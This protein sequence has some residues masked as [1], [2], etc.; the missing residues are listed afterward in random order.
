[1]KKLLV[2]ITILLS[3]FSFQSCR[4]TV[5]V[6]PT[7]PVIAARPPIPHPGYV[8]VDGEW[9][10]SGGRY[11]YRQGYWTSPRH[12]RVW[13]AGSWVRSGRGWHWQRGHWR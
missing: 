6:R 1:M 2:A 3:A 11:V 13:V 12:G 7:E 4:T 8:W 5:A 9:Y 10:R